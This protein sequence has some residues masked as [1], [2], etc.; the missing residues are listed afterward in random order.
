MNTG[1]VLGQLSA[2]QLGHMHITLAFIYYNHSIIEL[3]TE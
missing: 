1:L 2:S 3:M